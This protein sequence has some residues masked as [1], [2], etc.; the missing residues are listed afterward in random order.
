[1]VSAVAILVTPSLAVALTNANAG[2]EA[3]VREQFADAPVMID[4]AKCESGFRQFGPDGTPLYDPSHTYIGVFQISEA[5]HTPRAQQLGHDLTTVDGNLSYARSLY[6]A[7]GT[8]PWKG[9]LPANTIAVMPPPPATTP[10]PG[11]TLTVNLQAGMTHDQVKL[12]QQ[13]L[14]RNGY[15]LASA[16]VGSPGNETNY[17]GALT[18]ATVKKFQCDKGIA[19]EG[20]ESTTGFGRVGPRTRAALNAL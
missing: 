17:F 1:M 11:G 14:N 18:R 4:V 20:N 15:P 13:L 16:G 7:Q 3:K 6:N 10:A 9:C 5:I 8:G 12:I 2:I 19:C